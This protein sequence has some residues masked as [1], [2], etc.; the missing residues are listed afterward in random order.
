MR[1]NN[2]VKGVA[3]FLF[4]LLSEGTPA[5]SHFISGLKSRVL[6]L[7]FFCSKI[8]AKS[9]LELPSWCLYYAKVFLFLI[10]LVLAMGNNCSESHFGLVESSW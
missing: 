5:R 3:L 4:E 7:T 9:G 1:K 6:K 10:L 2:R 8:M